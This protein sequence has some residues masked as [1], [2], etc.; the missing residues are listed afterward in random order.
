MIYEIDLKYNKEVLEDRYC[1]FRYK[2]LNIFTIETL[3]WVLMII[4][5]LLFIKTPLFYVI[6]TTILYGI[7][8]CVSLS[9]YSEYKQAYKVI[10]LFTKQKKSCYYNEN[11]SCVFNMRINPDT[12]FQIGTIGFN[13]KIVYKNINTGLLD[14]NEG[15]LYLPKSHNR[16]TVI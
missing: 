12:Y 6:F 13:I 4:F 15:F 9:I 8:F 10:M 14:L 5:I 2:M 3:I 11:L 16:Y 1:K 7:S